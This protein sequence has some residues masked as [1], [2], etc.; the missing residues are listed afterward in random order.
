MKKVFLQRSQ[1][2]GDDII[3]K[4]VRTAVDMYIWVGVLEGISYR[5]IILDKI[6]DDYDLS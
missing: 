4:E 1:Y 6:T 3:N 5:G 2:L